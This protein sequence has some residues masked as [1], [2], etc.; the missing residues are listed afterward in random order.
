[1]AHYGAMLGIVLLVQSGIWRPGPFAGMCGQLHNVK[2]R[3]VNATVRHSTAITPLR[4]GTQL[5]LHRP[6]TGERSIMLVGGNLPFEHTFTM[7]MRSVR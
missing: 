7:C 5:V 2:E 1:M 4:W 3:V 6:H